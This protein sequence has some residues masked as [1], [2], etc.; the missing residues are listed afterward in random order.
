VTGLFEEDGD[1]REAA[2]PPVPGGV[3]RDE[4]QPIASLDDPHLV[5]NEALA[6]A[7]QQIVRLRGRYAAILLGVLIAQLAVADVVF[8][9]LG[10]RSGWR[11]PA[12][13]VNAWLG[14]VVIQVVAL[15]LAITK[16]IFSKEALQVQLV[17]PEP[18]VTIRPRRR[19]WSLWRR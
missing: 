8:V 5:V 13:V 17:P 11:M 4:A 2:E 15:V 14:A 10:Y 19:R 18:P 7:T 1:D 16:F 3:G 6:R 12:S 9:Y